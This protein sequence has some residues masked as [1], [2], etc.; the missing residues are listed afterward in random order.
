MSDEQKEILQMVSEGKITADDGVKL[1][2]ALE[3]GERK[4]RDHHSPAKRM[5]QQKKMIL[6][7]MRG[8]GMGLENMREIGHMVRNIVGDAVSGI[9]ENF[10]TDIFE[11]DKDRF[12]YFGIL[13]GEL[14][15]AEGTEL[16]ISNNRSRSGADINLEGVKGSSCSVIGDDAP[17]VSIFR[18]GES[19]W[20]KWDEGDITLC[21][22]ETVGKLSTST[23]GGDIVVS[24][25]KT[26]VNVSTRGGDI[27]IL[28][29]SYGF[30]AKTMGGDIII[31]LTDLWKEDSAV[32][33]MGGDISV[34]MLKGTKA[35]ISAKTF[36]GDINVQ[37]GIGEIDKSG[38]LGTSRVRVCLS[39]D[40][41][42]PAIR[43]KT[44]GGDISIGD[45]ENSVEE[46][47]EE[48]GEIEDDD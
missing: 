24:R 42:A 44:M 38:Q 22:P 6:E 11:I 18:Y 43:L 4:R 12:K 31:S 34:G 17:E 8:Q 21:V 45:L 16:Y 46:I 5:K 29:A 35:V 47:P 7:S 1:L 10:S 15:L 3:E 19:V 26:P 37:E 23:N 27:S 32:V 28:E 41:D 48:D 20:L 13:D 30:N 36:G 2:N 14:E 25:V 39:G 9:N 33:T 40:E